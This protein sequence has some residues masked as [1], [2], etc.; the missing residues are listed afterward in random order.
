LKEMIPHYLKKNDSDHYHHEWGDACQ[1]DEQE[2][3]PGH[4]RLGDQPE[5]QAI[6]EAVQH[7]AQLN[8]ILGCQKVRRKTRPQISNAFL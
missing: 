7:E 6:E 8:P 5:V 2:E 4:L 1:G 3:P